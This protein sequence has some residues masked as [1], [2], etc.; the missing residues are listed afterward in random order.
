MRVSANSCF[1]GRAALLVLH[2]PDGTPG[3][4]VTVIVDAENGHVVVNIAVGSLERTEF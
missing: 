3:S 2:T 1:H 4:F